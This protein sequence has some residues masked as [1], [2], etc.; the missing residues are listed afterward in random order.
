M[1]YLPHLF[2][3]A[4]GAVACAGRP[5]AVAHVTPAAAAPQPAVP[6]RYAAG[7]G[8]YRLESHSHVEQDAMGQTTAVDVG[9]GVL[10]TVALAD[11]AENLGVSITIDSLG[12]TSS[13]GGPDS[14]QLATARGTT[15]RLVSSRQGHTLAMTPPDSASPAAAQIAV[16][17]RDF[18]PE[19]PAGRSDSGAT[20]SDSSSTT[21]PSQ[22][23]LLTVHTSK[24]HV[25]MGWENHAG[26]RALHLV[27]T[28]AYTVS[29]SGQAQGQEMDLTGGGQRVS[30]AYVSADGVYLGGTLSDSS[31]VNA[32]L[33]SMG[34]VV[35]VRTR[36]HS[37]VTRLP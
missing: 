35:P 34:L 28:V 13:M 23:V 25:V 26:T 19:L 32:S 14:A 24:Q 18:L 12:V 7:T 8:R 27:T 20:W 31:L 11:T 36:S 17:L 37:T 16:G 5:A 33:V 3:A 9:T 2:V 30:D 29:G 21:T 15:V 4:L 22:G 6:L 1:K 10:L